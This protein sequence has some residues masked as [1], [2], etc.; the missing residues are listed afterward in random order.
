MWRNFWTEKEELNYLEKKNYMLF[1]CDN[2]LYVYIS[3]TNKPT[4][5][6]SGEVTLLC[7]FKILLYFRHSF[8]LYNLLLKLSPY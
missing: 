1:M 3:E 7:L 5:Y 4:L 8:T 6:Y 2:E